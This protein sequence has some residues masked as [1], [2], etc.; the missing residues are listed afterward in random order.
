[1]KRRNRSSDSPALSA[2]RFGRRSLLTSLGAV[3]GAALA[4]A[5]GVAAREA[6]AAPETGPAAGP[7]QAPT[8]RPAAVTPWRP[9]ATRPTGA[10]A[11][12][13]LDTLG[14]LV[15]TILPATDTPGALAAGVH[16]YLDDACTVDA[17]LKTALEA[18]LAALDARS[19]ALRGAAF[20]R[21]DPPAR[22]QVLAAVM[23]GT[24]D[25]RRFFT[26]ARNRVVDAYYKSEVG[27]LGEL[28]WVGHEFHDRFPG[29][30]THADPL[31]HPRP[32]WPRA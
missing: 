14:H 24:P 16:F 32:S 6:A 22:E 29:A 23:D 11:P 4:P 27:L 31:V 15:E 3:A 17:A 8:T 20:A 25:E 28:Q 10:L 1:M 9:L 12:A 2:K 26:L 30:C 18:G 19:Q 7:A 5:G 21:L 13:A